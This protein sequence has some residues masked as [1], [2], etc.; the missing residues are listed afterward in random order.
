MLFATAFACSGCREQ[1]AAQGAGGGQQADEVRSAQTANAPT[2]T[3]ES[4]AD[5]VIRQELNAVIAH[6][7]AL[8]D[9]AVR[10]TVAAGDVTATGTVGTE[11]ERQKINELAMQVNG[12][13]SVA[14]AVRVSPGEGG[15]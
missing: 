6:D 12:V 5:R 13:K 11:T 3:P 14:N 2:A 1:P 15:N 7:S 8:K 9:C 4:E 10:F